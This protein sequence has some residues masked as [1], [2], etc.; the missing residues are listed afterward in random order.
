MQDFGWKKN[1]KPIKF[2]LFDHYFRYSLGSNHISPFS[3]V[4]YV[5]VPLVRDKNSI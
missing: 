3:K 1:N 2:S 4:A 5:D